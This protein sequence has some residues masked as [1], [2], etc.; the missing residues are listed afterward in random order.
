MFLLG[1]SSF[2]P[3]AV[4]EG[5]AGNPPF[6]RT[7]RA[8]R[9][10]CGRRVGS[11]V[12]AMRTAIAPPRHMR[13]APVRRAPVR[14]TAFPF[15]LMVGLAML[16]MGA[17]TVAA[18]VV[19]DAGTGKTR[20][21]VTSPTG[22]VPPVAATAYLVLD[23]GTGQPLAAVAADERRP[24]GS[25]AKLMTA[26]LALEAGAP[27]DEVTVPPL[28]IGGDESQIGLTPGEVQRRDTLVAATLVASANDAARALAVDIGGSEARFVEMMN[29]EAA[30]LG[31]DDTH[32]ADPAGLEDEGQWS[33]ARDVAV[34]ADRLMDDAAFR[35][36]V[37]DPSVTVDGRE[38]AATNDLLGSY[39]GT[40]GV[41]TGHTDGA[42]WCIAA[43]ATRDGRRVIAVVLGAPTEEARDAAATTLLDWAFTS[44]PDASS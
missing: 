22:S 37:D 19:V 40:D 41:K 42:G 4:P 7:R 25:L 32:Y 30:A 43:S 27:G 31:L 33:T 26:H 28:D 24:V 9:P 14:L 18:T 44:A 23:A 2:R 38:H 17:V 5:R 20:L 12:P 29:A 39:R 21:F 13:P 11:Y 15:V 35:A 3:I 1:A 10:M 34:L 8:S 36:I 6:G 16:A